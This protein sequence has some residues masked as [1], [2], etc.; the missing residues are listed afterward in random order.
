MK[1][2]EFKKVV[3]TYDEAMLPYF[4]EGRTNFTRQTMI[5]LHGI[6]WYLENGKLVVEVVEEQ[7]EQYLFHLAFC[8]G[9]VY[10]KREK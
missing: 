2:Q 1:K 5:T 6:K 10:A 9:V 7:C 8:I 3:F 4:D